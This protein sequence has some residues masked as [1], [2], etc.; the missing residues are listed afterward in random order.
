MV[1]RTLPTSLILSLALVATACG[2]DATMDATSTTFTTMGS[3]TGTGMETLEGNSMSGDGDGD[4][5]PGDGDGDQTG[6]GDGDGD[7][8]DGDGDQTGDGDGDGDP[9]E[10]LDL[11]QD[12]YG[13]NCPMGTDCDDADYNNHEVDG[14]ANCADADMDG[15]WIGCDIYDNNKP[16]PDCDDLDFNVFSVD[17]C[18]NCTDNDNDGVWVMCDQYGDEK[19]GPDCA[20]DNPNVGL[21]D[22]EE[23]CNGISE[24][25]AGEID[26]APA[27]EMCP[28]EGVNAPNV[29]PMG[30]W[31]CDPPGPG[32]DGCVINSCVEQYFD[33]DANVP[34]GCEC[35]G[36]P[37]TESLAACSDFPQGYLG[38]VGE[39]EQLVNLVIGTVPQIDNGIG[40][41]RED[42]YSID[43][44]ENDAVG[45]RPNTGSARVSFAMNEGT[46]YRFEVYRTCNG[47]AF[48]DSLATQHGVGSPPSRE[49]WFFD[50]HAAPL[51]M[52]DPLKYLNSVTWPNKVYIRVFRVQNDNVC[53]NYQLNVQRVNN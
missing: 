19:P 8:G 34:N 28:P 18:A 4:G 10:C 26:N 41:G 32:Q 29:A 39:S 13:E 6:D 49:W 27:D 36:T 42:W 20:D 25:C 47:L 45:T 40:N 24:N 51:Q 53:N 15:Q 17:G 46:D 44:G 5:D 43:F 30:G 31:I 3:E 11:D 52:P 35:E 22:A 21:D 1:S 2:D 9:M 16:G 33:L 14:C 48:A 38:P 37:R 23:I 50:N 12:G 7:P